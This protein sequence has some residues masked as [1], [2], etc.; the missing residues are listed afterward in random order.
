[1]EWQHLHD[2]D[3]T[4]IGQRVIMLYH[5]KRG[6][7]AVP[8]PDLVEQANQWKEENDKAKQTESKA[9]SKRGA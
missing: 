9:K 3:G 1:M 2:P 4:V 7:Q 8:W 6:F 5:P